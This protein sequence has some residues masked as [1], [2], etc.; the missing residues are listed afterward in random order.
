MNNLGTVIEREYMTRVKKKSFI[1][2]TILMPFLMIGMVSVPIFLGMMK[3][4]DTTTVAVLDNTGKYVQLF[5]D[6]QKSDSTRCEG[7]AFV[8][9]D[10]PLTQYRD[11]AEGDIETII[12]IQDDLASNPKAV[13]IYSRG[14]IQSDLKR[15]VEDLLDDKIRQ[16]KVEGYGIPQLNDIVKDLDVGVDLQT[17]KWGEDGEETFSSTEMAMALGMLTAILIYMFVMVYG[18]MV[19][20]GVME[21]K[22]SRIVEVIVGSVK[23]FNLMMGKIIGVMLVGFTQIFIWIAMAVIA[24]TAASFYFGA[25][26]MDADTLQQTVAAAQQTMEATQQMSSA[27]VQQQMQQ[28]MDMI[29]E[30]PVAKVLD[31][32]GSLPIVEIIILFILYFF[33]GYLLFASFFAAVGAAINSQE[34]SSQFMMPVVFIMIFAMYGAMG[35][36]ENTDGPLAFWASLFPLTSPIVMMVR[37]PFGVPLWQE[38]LSVGLLYGTALLFIWMAGK[39]YRVGILMYGKKPTVKEMI[40]WMRYK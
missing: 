16:D 13:K 40:K 18:G 33:G 30:N 22:T 21:E 11:D 6:A 10:R 31:I 19:M 36:M 8:P 7:Y 14:E 32:F 26:S 2:L 39:I 29:P 25:S 5:L 3:G 20:Q 4:D 23:P 34:D 12:S 37:I 9:A 24:V 15:Y 28:A 35:S 27:E 38:L 17:V 1:L